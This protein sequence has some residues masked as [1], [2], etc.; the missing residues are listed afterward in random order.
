MDI[1]QFALLDHESL[2]FPETHARSLMLFRDS[3]V[4]P[5]LRAVDLEIDT[6]ERSEEPEAMFFHEDLAD[7]FQESVAGYLLT[8]QSMWER[9]LRTLMIKRDFRLRNGENIVKI[10]RAPWET[11]SKHFDDLMGFPLEAFDSYNDLY[12]LH[13][14]GNAIRHGNG[15]SAIKV[16][17]L[18]PTLWMFWMPPNTTYQA[19]PF[20]IKIPA[21]DPTHPPFENITLFESLLEQMILSVT[22]FWMDLEYIRCV[23]FH[24]ASDQISNQLTIWAEERINRRTSRYW[25]EKTH[26]AHGS[27]N[28]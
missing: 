10:Q 13:N 9:G 19:G 25:P 26:V 28:I 8:V 6:F 22:W 4:R 20:S 15:P 11:L 21:D 17:E 16:H 3:V 27:A 1:Y 12:L 23:S 2:G 18:A 14:L 7:L 24:S 5:S